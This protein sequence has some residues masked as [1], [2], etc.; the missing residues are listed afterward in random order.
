MVNDRT[1]AER[2]ERG[3]WTFRSVGVTIMGAARKVQ[4]GSRG[5][6]RVLVEDVMPDPMWHCPACG[7]TFAN[8]NQTHTCAAPGELDRHFDSTQPAV[9]ATFDRILA[10]VEEFGPVTVLPEKTRIAL[11]VRMSFAALMPRRRWLNGHLV[12]DRRIDSPRFSKVEVF[13]PRNVLHAFRLST[14][15]EVDDEFRGWLAEA[16]RVGGQHHLR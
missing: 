12:L 10:V 15:E 13:S 6:E 4:P 11:H 8:R 9:R 3:G 14:P 2:A 1:P 5:I 7:R 16:Y